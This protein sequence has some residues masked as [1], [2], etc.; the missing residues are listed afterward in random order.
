MVS[1]GVVW[2]DEASVLLTGFGSGTRTLG[3]VGG[4]PWFGRRGLAS[5]ASAV[6]VLANRQWLAAVMPKAL[7]PI[8]QPKP[9]NGGECAGWVPATGSLAD[10]A[11]VGDEL[12][13]AAECKGRPGVVGEQGAATRQPLF[14]RDL[15]GGRWRVLRW[16]EGNAPPILAD[17]DDLLTVGTQIS[18][19]LMHV[20]LIDLPAGRTQARFDTPD[21]YL[22]FA[23]PKRLVLSVPRESWPEETDFPLPPAIDGYRGPGPRSYELALYSAGG[24]R[25]AALGS[26]SSL[27]AV[28]H[29][30]LALME[31][32]GESSALVVRSLP[33]VEYRRVIGFN[34]PA[35]SL[36]A[37]AFRWPA[38][39]VAETTSAPLAQSEVGCWGS[40]YKPVS[41][42]FLATFDLAREEPFVAPAP[43]AHLVRPSD[44]GPPPPEP[45]IFNAVVND[46]RR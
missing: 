40:E 16:L 7:S 5:S 43:S 41:S 14:V 45:V 39:T 26:A 34:P 38:L 13:A 44:C 9:V 19:A 11:V 17:E 1:D 42:P 4:E 22:A 2:V 18:S 10:F 33:G 32:T 6:A 15:H 28:S 35:R 25:L 3:S 8:G 27:P 29:M 37:L 30:H 46:E 23:S 24:E 36:L 12:V 20:T 21:G 31:D